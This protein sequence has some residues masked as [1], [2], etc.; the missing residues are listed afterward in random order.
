MS[1]NQG[2][3]RGGNVIL[4]KFLK[5]ILLHVYNLDF[6]SF[7]IYRNCSKYCISSKMSPL[8]RSI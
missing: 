4:Q 6:L 5:N 8:L 2:Q 1:K 3:K 7:E